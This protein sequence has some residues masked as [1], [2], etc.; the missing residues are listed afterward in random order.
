M[1]LIFILGI[2]MILK[3][4]NRCVNHEK[5][6]YFK[7]KILNVGLFSR[8]LTFSNL[9]FKHR[10]SNS[11]ARL[12]YN[13]NYFNTKIVS[14]TGQLMFQS[15]TSELKLKPIPTFLLEYI[16]LWFIAI[17]LSEIIKDWLM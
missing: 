14:I 6:C 5:N 11:C 16:N 15:I 10:Y 13:N 3:N 1:M 8:T 17:D 7:L 12:S 4:A 9:I 2:S